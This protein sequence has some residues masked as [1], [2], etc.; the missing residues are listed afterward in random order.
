LTSTTDE[1]GKAS[2]ELKA[3]PPCNPREFIDGQ[4]YLLEYGF[5]DSSLQSSFTQDVNDKV[6]ILVYDENSDLSGEE[7]LAKWGRLY[8]IMYFLAEESK[9][10]DITFRKVIKQML[11]L[12]FDKVNHM[13]LTRDLGESSRVKVIEWINSLNQS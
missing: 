8:K 7:I 12:P 11:E 10:T 13:P 5:N 9:V 4:V 3:D 2:F 6:S 1:T